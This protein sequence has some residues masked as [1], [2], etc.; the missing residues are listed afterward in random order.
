[1]PPLQCAYVTQAEQRGVGDALLYAREWVGASPFV[2][3]FGD[4]LIEGKS[5]LQRLIAAHVAHQS[6]ATALVEAVER[7]KVSRYGVVASLEEVGD[8]PHEPFALFDIVEKPAVEDAPSRLVVAARW[9]LQPTIFAAL[10]QTEL[11]ARGE[12]NIT[13]AVR[14]LLRSGKTAWAVPLQTGEARRDIGNF[15]SFFAQFVRTALRDAEFGNAARRVAREELTRL[16][17]DPRQ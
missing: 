8:T 10:Q 4:C 5:P 1:M 9:V 13:D 3:A 14:A 2:V 11:D 15:E 6:E 7:A 12:R 17:S 16:E